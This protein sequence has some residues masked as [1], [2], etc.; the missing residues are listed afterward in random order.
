[1]IQIKTLASG[2]KG[3]CYWISDSKTSLLLEAGI[4]FKE[5]R[6]KL[7]FNTSDIQGCLISHSH[8]D[9][10]KSIKDV[11]KAGIDCYM[12]PDTEKETGIQSHRV[13]PV[14]A[15]EPFDVGTFRIL[16]F[17]NQHDVRCYGF[18]LA[19]KNGN[20]IL[21]ST[22]T[23]YVRYKFKGLSHIMIECNYSM[24][25]LNEKVADGSLDSFRKKRL[26]RSHFSLENVKEFLKANDLSKVQEIHLLHLSDSNSDEARFKREIQQLTGK[27]V[28]V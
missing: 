25:I 26:I 7:D 15:L 16:P 28:I 17:D 13:K 24:D 12:S 14:E 9:H 2:S 5:I 1:M 6:R 8:M 3:N 18:L 23:Y 10:A 21:F 19:S 4:P 20:K 11:C 27:V 22:D